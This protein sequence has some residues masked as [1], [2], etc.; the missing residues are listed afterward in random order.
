MDEEAYSTLG[1]AAM[2]C[3]GKSLWIC[4]ICLLLIISKFIDREAGL[5]GLAAS[6][7][8]PPMAPQILKLHENFQRGIYEVFEASRKMLNDIKLRSA[9]DV[10]R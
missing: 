7:V 1:W 9:G 3:M 4:E 8:I 2:H 5:C 10:S 6:Q